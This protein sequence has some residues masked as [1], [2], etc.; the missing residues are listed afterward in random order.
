MISPP[1]PTSTLQ[2]GLNYLELLLRARLDI[3]YG[4]REEADLP[5]FQ[6][7]EDGS[8]LATFFQASSLSL[9]EQLVLLL[10]LVPETDPGLLE[11][12]LEGYLTPDRDLPIFGGLKA[13]QHRGILPTGETALFLLGG[14]AVEDRLALRSLLTPD[15]ALRANGWLDLRTT[16]PGEPPLSGQLLPNG[17]WAERLLTGRVQPPAFSASFPATLITTPLEWADL[18]LNEQTRTE[19]G[20][21]RNY[22]ATRAEMEGNLAFGKHARR[23]YRALFHGPPGT[24]KTLT[25]ALLG[26]AVERPVYRV[27][28]SMVVSKWIGETEKNL[29]NLFAR[30]EHKGWILFFDEA[31]ALFGK[32]TEVKESKDKYANQETSYLLQRVENYDGLCILATNFKRNLDAAFVRRF[33]AIVPFLAPTPEERRLLWD[34]IL[35]EQPALAETIDLSK[36]AADYELTGANIANIVRHCVTECLAAGISSIGSELMLGAIKREYAK[37]ERLFM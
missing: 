29:A 1:P 24:G 26:K 6:L 31:D 22:L 21:L 3:H 7:P 32:R 17:E 2:T 27:D 25:A 11:R 16:P 36:L 9:A 18:V 35:P 33:E 20:Y 14:N 34:N 5:P 28:L 10:A 23:G 13:T 30:A 8:P 15:A 19:I 37:E 12:C 4:R